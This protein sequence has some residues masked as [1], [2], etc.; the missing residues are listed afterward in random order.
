MKLN[1]V[2]Q[3]CYTFTKWGPLKYL[4]QIEAFQGLF[5]AIFQQSPKWMKIDWVLRRTF[6]DTRIRFSSRYLHR[7]GMCY[8]LNLS[9]WNYV[10]FICCSEGVMSW[11]CS[12]VYV[13]N[14][15]IY[16]YI[17][18]HLVQFLRLC[19]FGHGHRSSSIKISKNCEMLE[20]WYRIE[21]LMASGCTSG[22]DRKMIWSVHDDR[23]ALWQDRAGSALKRC[24]TDWCSDAPMEFTVTSWIKI[25][26]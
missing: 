5:I 18:L 16:A 2:R 24:T 6:L 3:R 22:V 21:L 25:Y 4:H 20:R 10:Y 14:E 15:I 23:T 7:M 8:P 17:L 9:F 11:N 13:N 26:G 12:T 19:H 1:M